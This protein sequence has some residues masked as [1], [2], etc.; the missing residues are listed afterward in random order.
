MK[1]KLFILI[2]ALW[3]NITLG[4]NNQFYEFFSLI[5]S[6]KGNFLQTVYNKEFALISS[7]SGNFV[8][9]HQKKLRWHTTTPNEQI[10]LLNNSEL[11]QIDTELEQAVLQE[12]KDFSKTPLYWLINKPSSMNHIPKFSHSESGIDWYLAI[13]THSQPVEFGFIDGLLYAISLDNKLGQ[14]I[15]I[16]FDQLI[17][18]PIITPGTFKLNINPNF[19]I[20]K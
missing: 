9:Q 8:F 10:L 17:I 16:T 20:I 5:K 14:I 11:W 1:I 2:A 6:L 3:T 15:T 19:D 13:N 7:T 4:K 18:N 12:N